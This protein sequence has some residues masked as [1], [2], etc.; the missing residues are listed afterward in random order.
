MQ[1]TKYL[2]SLL[3][4]V[5]VLGFVSPLKVVQNIFGW[6][7]QL[8]ISDERAAEVQNN[9]P[10]DPQILKWR[11]S[12]QFWIDM[13]NIGCTEEPLTEGLRQQQQNCPAPAQELHD[14]CVHHPNTNWSVFLIAC[15]K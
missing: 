1:R 4:L 2:F 13:F 6:H 5:L 3:A 10:N 12:I 7:E 14:I 9:N 8:G 15:R 11:N